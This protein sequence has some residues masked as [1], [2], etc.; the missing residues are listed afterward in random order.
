MNVRVR[1]SADETRARIVDVAEEHF[2]RVGY[3]KTAVADLADALQMSSANIYRFFPSKS[4]INN[5]ICQKLLANGEVLAV[6]IARSPGDASSRIGRLIR[7]MHAYNK[8]RLTDEHRIHDMVEMA[9]AEHWPA[10]EQHCDRIGEIM[11]GLLSEGMASGEFAAM[12]IGTTAET[13]FSCCASLFH[14]TLIAQCADEDQAKTAA[15][16]AA[17]VLR[18]LTN[19]ASTAAG[20]LAPQ[21]ANDASA[22]SVKP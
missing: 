3:A 6:E 15:D 2:R 16:T 9:M 8:S 20:A 13:I 17:F 19:H 7:E 18:A 22:E 1:M 4:S 11:A 5:A 10:I 14:P 12:D 21:P